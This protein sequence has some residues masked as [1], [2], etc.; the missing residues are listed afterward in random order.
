MFLSYNK[1][2]LKDEILNKKNNSKLI[3]KKESNT[4]NKLIFGD[5]LIVLNYLLQEYKG[6]V[7]L[8]YIDPP[9]ATNTDF[10]INEDR[11][12]TISSGLS[13]KIAYSD[14]LTGS[15]YLEF[16][17]ERLFFLKELMSDKGS[18]YVHIDYKI[19]HYVKII[20]DEVFGIENFRNDITRIKCNP[21]N[22][23]REAY[24]N[25]K[26]LLLFYSKTKKIIWNNI[27]AK[28]SD[29]EILKRY[30]KIDENGRRYTT[31]PLHA[32]GETKNGA[33]GGEWRGM[34]PP[35]GRHWRCSPDVLEDLELNRLIE[36]SKTGNPR[37]KMYASGNLEKK[38]QDIW[39]FKDTQRPVYPTE[40]N[41]DLLEFILLNSS[42]KNSL[43]LDCFCGSGTTLVAA[44]KNERI[45]IGIDSSEDAI[46]V[47]KKRLNELS[48]FNYY[49]LIES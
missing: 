18:I 27:G 14:R 24:G 28:L 12:A 8:V 4:L 41:L 47:T 35:K 26:D 42:N 45:W 21:K 17:R 23:K 7:D 6:K 5:N 1:K 9:F 40:K 43:V 36:W 15:T 11:T 25:T 22:F 39:E 2:Q 13:D 34:F 29:D 37:K 48:Q 49:E 44:S 3:L 10:K 16:I 38:I 19:G 33:T 46:R 20:M 30:P 32:P 31:V